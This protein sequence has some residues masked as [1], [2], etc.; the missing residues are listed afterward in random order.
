VKDPSQTKY[1]PH[2]YK[3][4]KLAYGHFESWNKKLRN[5]SDCG[6]SENDLKQEQIWRWDL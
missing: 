3:E 1:I 5:N 2:F 4:R 6:L